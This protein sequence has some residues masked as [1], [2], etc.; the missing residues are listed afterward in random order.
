VKQGYLVVQT[1]PD[2]PGLVRVLGMNRLPATPSAGARG[3]DIPVVRYAAAFTDLDAALMHAHAGLRRGLVDVDARLYRT[4]ALEAVAVADAIELRHRVAYL[5]PEL[6]AAPRLAAETSR[7][8]ARHRL[9]D[10]VWTGV[11][12]AGILLLFFKLVLVF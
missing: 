1:R 12:I 2:R 9:A 8:R 7:L 6:A 10:K 3:S 4:D 11:G 5:D